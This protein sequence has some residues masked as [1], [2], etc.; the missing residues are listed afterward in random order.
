MQ[1]NPLSRL[2]SAACLL[3]AALSVTAP[4]MA[5]DYKSEYRLST[6]LGKAFP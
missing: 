6:V 2:L 5:A 1:N 4:A 3:L